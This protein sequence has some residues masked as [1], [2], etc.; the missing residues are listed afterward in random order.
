MRDPI[1]GAMSKPSPLA[2][3]REFRVRHALALGAVVLV[4]IVVVDAWTPVD[5]S[6]DDRVY[7]PGSQPGSVSLQKNSACTK[8]HGGYDPNAEPE[9]SLLGSMMAHATRDPLWLACLTVAEQDSIWALG[10]PNAGDLC[11]R[12]HTPSG[13]LAGRS[14]PPNMTSLDPGLGDFEGISCTFCHRLSDPILALEQP[15][16]PPEPD[17]S[18]HEAAAAVTRDV[19]R[20]V[21]TNITLFS[22]EDF[23]DTTTDLPVHFEAGNL[24][25]YIEAGGGQFFV[26]PLDRRR[27]PRLD[28]DPT[29][30]FFYSR[31]LRSKS[32]CG[33]CHDVSNPVLANISLD[34]D[35][36]PGSSQVRSA[37]SYFH[38]ERTFS[39][40]QLSAYGLAGGAPTN[41]TIAAGGA[42]WARTCQDCHMPG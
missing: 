33:T 36:G 40:F 31:Y 13:W 3:L 11:I 18:A 26:D 32:M 7:M 28:V 29:H 10:N 24:A 4:G 22:G 30:Q 27:G 21:L 38:V 16:V 6:D 17:G 2:V 9:H 23:F 35:L 15:D 12:C 19:D 41:P 14:N 37:A 8:C 34:P 20:T 25:K 5:I 39:E 1:G 42:A